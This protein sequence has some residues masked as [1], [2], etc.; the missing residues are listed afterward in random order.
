MTKVTEAGPQVKTA[1]RPQGQRN[2]S[3]WS[4]KQVVLDADPKRK[5]MVSHYIT[6][7]SGLTWQEAKAMRKA[8]RT[9]H[10][11]RERAAAAA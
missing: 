9:L 7:K 5:V 1:V 4:V 8:N 6:V 10:I 11:V 2:E 3:M